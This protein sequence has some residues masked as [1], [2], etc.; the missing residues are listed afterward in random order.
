[1]NIK[2]IDSKENKQ[3]KFFK[4]LFI[5]KYRDEYKLFLLEGNKLFKEALK[6]NI[7]I[8]NIICTEKMLEKLKDFENT[9]CN[10]NIKITVLSLNLFNSLTE[11][12]HSEGIITIVNYIKEKEISS[13]T[14]ILLDEINDPGNFGT[15][16]RCANAFGI[17]DILTLN[18]VD[19]YNP[20]VL[21]ASMG[22][23]FRTN[24]LKVNLEKILQL[25]NQGYRLISTTLNE[26]SKNLEE[27][28]FNGKNII[29]MGNEANGVK[30]EILNIS[31][32]F[33]KI[34]ID[35]SMESLNVSIASAIIMNEIYKNKKRSS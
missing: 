18:S 30:K 35:N 7:E 14:M 32:E 4:S 12:T 20:K 24:I 6:E 17:K 23:I 31:D 9:I 2:F 5:K 33:L 3:Y 29:I 26:K 28:S 22:A 1:M 34:E 16:I 25:K 15:I 21:R 10:K 19:K 11:M 13:K 8:E 27:L